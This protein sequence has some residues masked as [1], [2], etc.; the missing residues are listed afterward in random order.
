M[1]SQ[2]SSM[3]G[4][5]DSNRFLALCIAA[6][7][8]VRSDD[9]IADFCRHLR[10]L[11]F[12]VGTEWWRVNRIEKAELQIGESA[13]LFAAWPGFVEAVERNRDDRTLVVNCQ[14]CGT[15]AKSFGLAID[16]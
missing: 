1:T 9:P 2:E 13:E 3:C 7:F 12:G 14:N 4:R 5:A 10:I 11:G 8:V 16:A 6:Q 15:L